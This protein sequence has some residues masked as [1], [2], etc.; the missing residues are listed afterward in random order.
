MSFVFRWTFRLTVLLLSLSVLAFSLAY[1]LAAQ[2]LPGYNKDIQFQELNSNLEIIRDTYNVPH[3]FGQNDEDVFF[4]LGYSHAQDRLWQMATLRRRAQGRLSEVFGLKTFQ[5]DQFYRRLDLYTLAQSSFEN[6]SD[7]AKSI[8]QSYAK[9]VNA[10]IREVNEQ[11]LG[12]GAPEMFLFDAPFAIW[13]PVDSIV[14]LKMLGVEWS[15]QITREILY[16]RLL[17]ALEDDKRALD[18]MPEV[19]GTGTLVPFDVHH[20]KAFS[21]DSH[22]YQTAVSGLNL[23]HLPPLGL[24][25]ASNAFAAAPSRAASG[26][27]LLANDPHGALSA[28]ALWYLT[29]LELETGGV[30]GATIPGLPLILSGRSTALGWAITSS[31][32]DDQDLILETV[33]PSQPEY[34]VSDNG[35]QKFV[36][37]PSIIQI[38]NEQ[39]VTIILRWSENGPILSPKEQGVF[40]VT[41]EN[42]VVALTATALRGDDLSLEAFLNLMKSKSVSKAQS[43]LDAFQSPSLTLTL[44]DDENIAL[45][46][47]GLRP[48]R[49]PAHQTLG[50]YPS[51]GE[52]K[53]NRWSGFLPE[54][55]SPRIVN[56]ADGIIV[57]SNNKLTD[58][59]F[60]NH[61]A[62]AWGDSQRIQRLSRLL[63]ERKVHTNESFK[64]TQ[65]DNI[66]YTAR[67]L[68][69]LVAADLFFTEESGALGTQAQNRR[70]AMT[71]LADWNGD[72]DEYRPEPLIYAAWM[73]ALQERLIRDE[74]GQLADAFTHVEPLFIERV[75]RNIEG[76]GKWCDIAQSSVIES[77]SDIAS[78]AL[79]DALIY[80]KQ[81]FGATLSALRWGDAHKAIHE[82]SSLGHIPLLK[83]FVNIEQPTSGGD[84][85]I[86]RGR[87][88]GTGANPFLNIHAAGYRGVYDFSDPDSSI[89]VIATGQSGHPLSRHYD[90]L[91][92][93]WRRGEYWRMSLDKDLTKSGAIGITRMSPANGSN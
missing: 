22:P 24:A 2:S 31:Y 28:P 62:F 33:D 73:R 92:Q 29:R 25:G 78:V 84:H 16:A 38:R 40:E 56:P 87:T 10:R 42:Y 26:G 79:D 71:L 61:G 66:S 60:P 51:L 1:Y 36:S 64:E 50:K 93:L 85:T 48:E 6:F 47:T 63:G 27:A 17:L 39:P 58:E 68:L 46:A 89:F 8:L 59:A 13:T 52:N 9:G 45:F 7:P 4:G 76:A 21:P 18:L 75:F 20:S 83:Y 88:K 35:P 55:T 34:Y 72:M 90:D 53:N 12:R 49:N 37:R 69:P 91:G 32:I 23:D 70:L 5:S 11:S 67:S 3:I 15:E 57:T 43:A 80:L 54:E 74:I 14:I 41:P 19:P 44:V 82:H 77:C 30:I 81:N 86:Q 65:L